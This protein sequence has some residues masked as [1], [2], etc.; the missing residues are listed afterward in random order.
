MGEAGLLL[1]IAQFCAWGVFVIIWAQMG[2]VDWREQK[3]RNH[4][5]LFWL[6]FVFATYLLIAVQSLLGALGYGKI[7][8]LPGYYYSLLGHVAFSV[9][10]A[11][12]L[13]WLRIWP[14]GDVKLFVLLALF[15][16]LTRIPGSFRSGLLFLEVLINIFIPAAA[17]LL[18][19]AG[20]YLWRTRFAHQMT[21]VKNYIIFRYKVFR[22]PE[23]DFRLPPF[24]LRDGGRAAAAAVRTQ[25]FAAGAF[26][27]NEFIEWLK[28]TRENP[29][30]FMMNMLSRLAMM[31][32]MS[33]ISYSLNDLITSNVLKVLVCFALMFAW[34]RVCAFF[35]TGWALGVMFCGASIF[36]W[37]RPDVN[38]P[39]LAVIF[40]HITIFTFFIFL[41]MQ[42]AFKLI[43]GK[44]K[45]L[46]FLPLLMTLPSLIPWGY[47]F[48]LVWSG[49]AASVGFVAGALGSHSAPA[50]PALPSL[51]AF[52]SIPPLAWI[53]AADFPGLMIWA[54][55][56]MFFGLALVF[57]KIWDSES[58]K[59]VPVAH[60]DR[61]MTLG[62]AFVERI[63]AD[64]NFRDEHFTAFYADG[65]TGEQAEALKRWCAEAGI[66]TVPLAPTISFANW[67]FLGYF[68]TRLLEGHVLRNLY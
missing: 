52:P 19:T 26:V 11:Y 50:A 58:Y 17:F 32:V 55:M 9:A 33:M 41:G 60:L 39:A 53:S 68:L 22:L 4:L 59:S 45:Y 27:K 67:I 20:W 15:Y 2:W 1:K 42:L 21:Q 44:S 14:A 29:V 35:G 38:F 56:G 30:D 24:D 63:E 12:S 48:G 3:I 34:G 5:L 16:P 10:A 61:F 47:L 43:A 6:K 13:W 57:V 8:L 31:V 46:F 66:E 62:P 40:G 7:Y 54:F 25:I 65:L 49:L 51:P 23:F 18:L 28:R 37:R 64:E 36:L